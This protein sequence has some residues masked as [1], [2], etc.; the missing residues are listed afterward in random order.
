MDGTRPNPDPAGSSASSSLLFW[1]LIVLAATAFVPCV[2][3]P[4]WRDYQALDLAVQVEERVTE[5]ARTGVR[6]LRHSARAIRTDPAVAARL[7]RRELSYDHLG[8]TEVPVPGV[9]PANPNT[10]DPIALQPV[11]PPLPIARAIGHLPA[12][13]YDRLFVDQ[14]T[15]TILMLLSGGLVLAALVLC[16]P[17]DSGQADGKSGIA[18]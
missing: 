1:A 9:S 15:R 18:P 17:R 8:Q 2:L 12:I 11:Q 3:L 13:N 5:A 10:A 6:R 14:P 16:R 7:A 4:P